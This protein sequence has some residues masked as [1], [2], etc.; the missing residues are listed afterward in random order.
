MAMTLKN[1]VAFGQFFVIF[2]FILYAG[3]ILFYLSGLKNTNIKN[4]E[5]NF[6]YYRHSQRIRLNVVQIQQYLSDIGATRGEDGLADGLTEAEKNYKKLL[7]EIENEKK[8]AIQYNNPELIKTLDDIKT[9]SDIYYATGV[10]MANLYIH[11]GTKAGNAFMGEFDKA[12]LNLQD[13][14]EPFIKQIATNFENEVVS[15]GHDVSYMFQYSVWIPLL[16]IVL[17]AIFTFYFV[18]GLNRELKQIVQGLVDNTSDLESGSLSLYEESA[19]LSNSTI[20]QAQSIESSASAIHEISSTVNSNAD[21]ANKAKQATEE[22]VEVT[23]NG[24]ETLNNVLVAIDGISHN[25]IEVIKEMQDTNREVSEFVNVIVEIEN[26]TKIINDIVFQTKL[27]AFNA[28]VEAARAGEHGKGFSVVAEEVGNLSNM[29][30]QAAKDISALLNEGVSKIKSIVERSNQKVSR[31]SA[32]GASKVESSMKVVNESKEVLDVI[33]TSVENVKSMV[34]EIADASIQ[35]ST[36][37]RDISSSFSEIEVSIKENSQ[38][39]ESSTAQSDILRRQSEKL[40][41]VIQNFLA[42][43]EGDNLPVAK[44]EWNDRFLLRVDDMDHEHHTL[45]EKMNIFLELLN[46][47]KLSDIQAAYGDLAT[48]TVKHFAHEEKYMESI[49]FPELDHHKKLHKNLVTKVLEYKQGLDQG[50]L[51]KQAIANFLKNW[52][53]I[54]IVGQDQRYARHSRSNH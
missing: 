35:Q 9:F 27:L 30:G 52:L 44:F 24:I 11:Q 6:A 14:V 42:L 26:K 39:A 1:K 3:L 12:S 7:E 5:R 47:N 25:N 37:V 49:G 40:A 15:V 33:L 23:K 31:L 36:G 19:R 2:F 53:A 34:N 13:K 20:E 48:F 10:K 28:S 4:L 45:I 46:S 16:V 18:R 22:G 21:Y 51:N 29:S 41:G 38:I 54:H 32:E 50:K 8:L 43:I 17:F